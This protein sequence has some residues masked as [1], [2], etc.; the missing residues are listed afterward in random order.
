MPSVDPSGI[1]L[2]HADTSFGGTSRSALQFARAWA[3]TGRPVH[4]LTL[5][6]DTPGREADSD[7]GVHEVA[8]LDAVPWED[9]AIVHLHHWNWARDERE[10]V[11]ELIATVRAL[12]HPPRLL[13]NNIFSSPDTALRDW[14]APA[15]VGVLGTWSAHQYLT[16]MT[17]RP[18]PHPFVIAN[19]QDLALFRP[20]S[21]DE[22][23]AARTRLGLGSERVLL[24]VG[25]PLENK[26]SPAYAAL[27]RA[28][29]EA[30]MRLVLV[31][32]PDG[33][34]AAVAGIEGTSVLDRI[35]D[36][37]LMRDWYWA[38]DAFALDAE[39]GESF[40]NVIL[41]AL[42]AGLPVVYRGRPL[43][44][45]TPWEFRDLPG[46][47]YVTGRAAWVR[48]CL[49]A[50]R[51]GRD[52]GRTSRDVARIEARYSIEAVSGQLARAA[53]AL[54]A[55]PVT[56][57]LVDAAGLGRRAELDVLH[58]AAVALRHNPAAALVK[59]GVNRLRAGGAGAGIELLRRGR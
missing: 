6:H 29:A 38:A 43:R 23:A 46:F 21:P 40:G 22:R 10:R 47:T 51:T 11:Q 28:V 24:R 8:G 13:T 1:L 54:D 2:V 26:W 19:P 58:R 33:V 3:R 34:R 44:D 16:A 25:S 53:E 18:H 32:P 42:G 52:P 59:N 39:R 15:A 7:T 20:P 49:D 57:S 31:S 30:R 27:A 37:D 48:A 45:N 55:A 4:V 56:Q 50:A 17:G 41:E 35:R 14:P 12:P 5:A 9:I 36:D